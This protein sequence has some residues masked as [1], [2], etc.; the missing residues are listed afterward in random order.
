[1]SQSTRPKAVTRVDRARS[2]LRE[3]AR[4]VPG[5]R[6]RLA[7]QFGPPRVK[8]Q[9]RQQRLELITRYV[10]LDGQGLE[11][12]PSHN[13]LLSKAAGYDLRIADY[14]DRDGLIEKYHGLKPTD[15]I[16]DVDYVLKGGLLTDEIPDRFD[17]IVASHVI[18]HT[19]CL[20]SFINECGGLLKPGGV[21]TLAIPDHRYCFDRFRDRTALG[22][23]IDVHKQGLTVHSEGS[24]IEHNLFHTRK[25]GEAAWSSGF[26]GTYKTSYPTST[27]IARG[28]QAVA[29]EYVDTHNW[30]FTPY[31]FRLL[32]HDLQSLGLITL[33][34]KSFTDTV[35]P[36]FYVTLTADGAGSGLSRD[37]LMAKSADEAATR[38]TIRFA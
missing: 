23:V 14:L 31:H 19:V 38:E 30:V 1:M 35:G 37:E 15:Q 8:R 5:V 34:E 2:L 36:E 25:G 4:I 24:V 29:G 3:P 26:P 16:E 28:N 18:E 33:A 22:R 7:R 21:L 10:N 27:A 32:V 9:P 20:I 11:I 13:P 6:R 17:Y 12:G